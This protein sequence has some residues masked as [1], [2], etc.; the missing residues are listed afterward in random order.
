M[1]GEEEG[2][3]VREEEGVMVGEVE[4]EED[5]MV[6][7]VEVVRFV[8]QGYHFF[9]TLCSGSILM[10]R[11]RHFCLVICCLSPCIVHAVVSE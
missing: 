11:G 8:T 9:R 7:M 6:D 2:V 10:V 5:M 4:K 3:M 1:V